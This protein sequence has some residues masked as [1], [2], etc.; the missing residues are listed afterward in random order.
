MKWVAGKHKSK[1]FWDSTLH[2]S[3]RLRTKPQETAHAVEDVEHG[4]QFFI[5]DGSANLFSYFGN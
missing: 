5:T 1:Q 3:E 2:L 4:K